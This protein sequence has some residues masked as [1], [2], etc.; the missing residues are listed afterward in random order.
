[1]E[2]VTE[3]VV[4]AKGVANH[5]KV[6]Q[7]GASQ[8]FEVPDV[9]EF[10]DVFPM[11]MPGMS[12]DRDI[13]FVIELKPGTTPIY[14]TPSRM[15]ILELAELKEHI[16]ELVEKGFICPSSSLW[17]APMIFVLKKDGTLRLCVDYRVL[18]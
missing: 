3:P 6:N 11:D 8:G 14:K 13:D 2:F 16:K 5:A 17:G 10:S 9:N 4:I 12:P 7:L 15:T 18:N 1:M